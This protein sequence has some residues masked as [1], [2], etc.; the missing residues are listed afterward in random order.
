MLP[1]QIG[2]L[3]YSCSAT[4]VIVYDSNEVRPASG[5]SSIRKNK[6]IRPPV[7]LKNTKLAIVADTTNRVMQKD[8]QMSPPKELRLCGKI[9]ATMDAQ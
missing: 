3:L 1:L 2:L 8:V 7:L 9:Q 5:N 6:T 4:H